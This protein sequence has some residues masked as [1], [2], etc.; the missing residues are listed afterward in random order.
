MR[1]LAALLL[2]PACLLLLPARARAQ[3]LRG[4][5]SELFIF[6]PGQEP[7]FLAGSATS[8]NPASIRAHG[9]HFLPSAAA[10]NGSV[11]SFI[12]R[13]LAAS[14][15][16]VPIGATTSGEKF[17]FEGG[18]PVSTST[19]AGPIFAE[20][21]QTLGHGRVLA[22]LNRSSFHFASLRGV[23][24]NDVELVFTHENVDFDGCSAQQG[25][26]CAKMGVPVL[27]NDIMQFKLSL[28]LD[29]AVTSFYVTYGITD[30]I[31]L[32]IVLPMLSTNFE[33][34]SDAQIIPFGGPTAAHF[35]G[36]T[37][38]SPVLQA[39]R[40]SSGSTFG[41]GDVAARLKVNAHQ[42]ARS[43]VAF[44]AD[45]RF[46]TGDP[47]DLLG[48]GKFAMRAL[49]IV[50]ATFDAFSPHAN[51][52]YLYRT[53]NE[54]NDAVLATAGFDHLLG[55]NVTLA[56]DVVSEFQ[57][58]R[59]TLILPKPV[60]YDA[61]F[62]RTVNPT[63]IPDLRDDIVNGSFGL[64]FATASRALIVANALFPLNT[65]GMRARHTFTLGVEYAF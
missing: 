43:G 2:L 16:N 19:S 30:H 38:E 24:L 5:L 53:G 61:P 3:G 41:I 32:G 47:D 45:A 50:S 21:A 37:P 56:A 57:V 64:K 48:S 39:S 13:A 62:R 58:G 55:S 26:D 4:K 46:P 23:P 20:R 54:Q 7:L 27:E 9:S 63:S 11:I 12:S 36:G 18:V 34:R 42:S 17:R 29:V 49:A 60:S 40:T 6:G 31:D 33:G 65:G 44:L 35:F 1:R 51:V 59:S 15:S 22:G 52:G 25:D 10:E 14:V 8:S 28:D